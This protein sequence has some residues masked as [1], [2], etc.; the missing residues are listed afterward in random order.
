MKDEQSESF[1]GGT[2]GFAIPISLLHHEGA[3]TQF[4]SEALAKGCRSKKERQI[5]FQFSSVFFQI[6]LHIIE[7]D[8]EN[9]KLKLVCC[10][11]VQKS[12]V[13]KWE[14]ITFCIKL[15]DRICD[16]E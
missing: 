8:P 14:N 13:K 2:R 10:Y 11:F 7:T 5:L 15:K 12:Q 16:C 4:K 1:G 9:C 6:I 3:Q